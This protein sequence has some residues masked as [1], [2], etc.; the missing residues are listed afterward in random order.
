MHGGTSTGPLDTP[1]RGL[2]SRSPFS[3]YVALYLLF[4]EE[5]GP[6]WE[7]TLAGH[8]LLTELAFQC[9]PGRRMTRLP[10]GS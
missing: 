3:R 5:Y 10:P 9:K 2:Y 4:R 6:D 7:P 8:R 1:A